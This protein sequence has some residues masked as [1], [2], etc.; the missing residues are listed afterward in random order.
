MFFIMNG[1]WLTQLHALV[2]SST[3]AQIIAQVCRGLARYPQ[4]SL[5]TK[6]AS[7]AS[8]RIVYV[9]GR[10]VRLPHALR[11]ELVL[12]FM[13]LVLVKAYLVLLKDRNAGRRLGVRV[14]SKQ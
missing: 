7:I 12:L 1:G 9:M 14:M 6:H 13:F 11:H 5:Q 8:S 4:K 3:S 10:A 2:A